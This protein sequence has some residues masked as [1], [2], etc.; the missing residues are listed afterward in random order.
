MRFLVGN[1]G[2]GLA[3]YH[4]G[5]QV[6]AGHDQAHAGAAVHAVGHV[7]NGRETHTFFGSRANLHH[8]GFRVTN[9]LLEQGIHF[10]GDFTEQM[11]GVVQFRLPIDDGQVN[12]FG[13]IFR[14]RS[15]RH[16]RRT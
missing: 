11:G 7:D 6:L 10:P 4:D 2:F 8:L 3:A 13:A 9:F 5:F 14:E 16:N 1:G 12:P 15:T